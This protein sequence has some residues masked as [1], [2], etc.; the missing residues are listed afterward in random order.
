[1]I[2][3]YSFGRRTAWVEIPQRFLSGRECLADGRRGR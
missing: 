3:L 1:M 2:T